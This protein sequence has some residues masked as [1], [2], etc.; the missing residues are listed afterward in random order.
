MRPSP[1]PRSGARP[2]VAGAL[3]LLLVPASI[4]LA[5]PVPAAPGDPVDRW[6]R[7]T[8]DAGSVV[9]SAEVGLPHGVT[10]F[11][12]SSYSMVAAT[13][14]GTAPRVDVRT[15]PGQPWRRLPLLEDGPSRGSAERVP[16]LRGT[17]LVWTGADTGLDVRVTGTGHRDLEL[18][19]VDPGELP[20]DDDA[21]AAAPAEPR[22]TTRELAAT[23]AP[24]PALR[25]RRD[26]G[27]DDSWRNG[28]PVYT[29]GLKQ[30]HVHHTATGNSYSRSDVPGLIRG[31]YRYHTQSLGWFDIGYNFLVDRFGRAWVGRSGGYER[32][33]RGAHTLGFN[34]H[35]V[36]IAMIGTLQTRRPWRPAVRMVV[37]L[38]AWKL[39]KHGR[40]ATGR[41]RVQSTGSDKYRDGEW[42][43][44]PVIDGH[45]DTNDT[46]CPGQR[47]YDKLP[48]I[49][50]RAQHWIDAYN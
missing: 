9:R 35:S 48:T 36:G 46:A 2:L 38:A 30:V 12:T 1:L 33:V 29:R 22:T 50:R 4:G 5:A 43:R 14:R 45:R 24:R 47:L 8:R 7:L 21:A 26:W 25:T 20:S 37:R 6:V 42:V 19:L 27:A 44:L 31:M 23:R 10:R 40:D 17:D 49:R 18:V 28:S 39:D 41:V 3:T 13:W 15:A 34:E 32:L 11:A 16:G